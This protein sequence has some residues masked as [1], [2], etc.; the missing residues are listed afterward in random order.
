MVNRCYICWHDT[1]VFIWS[2]SRVID[3][4]KLNKMEQFK[5]IPN[6]ERIGFPICVGCAKK[7]K[8]KEAKYEPQRV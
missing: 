1:L 2:T 8:L 3:K 7:N 6:T 5:S 4:E